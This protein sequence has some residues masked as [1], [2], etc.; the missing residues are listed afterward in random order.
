LVTAV[1]DDRGGR[2]NPGR[3]HSAKTERLLDA[4]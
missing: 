1:Q 3:D 4:Q 2:D